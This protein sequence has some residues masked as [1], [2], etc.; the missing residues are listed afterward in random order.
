MDE[1]KWKQLPTQKYNPKSVQF[2][3]DYKTPFATSR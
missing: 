1:R 3:G 2:S